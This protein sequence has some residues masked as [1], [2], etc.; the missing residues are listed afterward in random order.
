MARN[1]N[2]SGSTCGCLVESGGPGIEVTGIG[3][4]ANPFKI[5]NTAATFGSAFAIDDTVTVQLVLLGSGTTEDPFILSANTKV[6]I[7][8]I[9]DVVDGTTPVAGEVLTAVGSGAGL[10]WEYQPTSRPYTTANRPLPAAVAA[11]TAIFNT[12]TGKPNWNRG[13]AWVD[14]T[15]AVV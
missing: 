4:A 2:C 11:G 13:D 5:R 10:H 7:K 15:G 3:T 14:A 12:T 6:S 8:D 9:E 1:C